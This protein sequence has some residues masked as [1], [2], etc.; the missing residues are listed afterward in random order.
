MTANWKLIDNYNYK[1]LDSVWLA[2]SDNAA[3]VTYTF[4]WSGVAGGKDVSG[5]ERD[6]R[7][8]RRDTQG[9]R[10]AHEHLSNG[11]WRVA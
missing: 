2:R 11:Q 5:A 7:V 6:T 9:R 1:I 3:A 10:I 8:F 4:S